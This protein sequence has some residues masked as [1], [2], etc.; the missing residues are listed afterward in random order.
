MKP[1]MFRTGGEA[2][3]FGLRIV[4]LF[5]LVGGLAY[6]GF[7]LVAGDDW[8]AEEVASADGID[9][10]D[11]PPDGQGL[12]F[13]DEFLAWPENATAGIHIDATEHIYRCGAPVDGSYHCDLVDDVT[14]PLKLGCHLLSSD[15]FFGWICP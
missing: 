3:F 14:D 8:T 1:G 4:G 9:I 7:R 6:V 10:T 5:V 2:V 13:A 15:Y 12:T 11:I